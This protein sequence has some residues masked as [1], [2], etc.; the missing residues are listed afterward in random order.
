MEAAGRL[1]LEQPRIESSPNTPDW[2]VRADKY[3]HQPVERPLLLTNV[4]MWFSGLDAP[5]FSQGEARL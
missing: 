3:P 2:M 4:T 5:L 1:R